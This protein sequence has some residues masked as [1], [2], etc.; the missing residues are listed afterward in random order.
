MKLMQWWLLHRVP[1]DMTV[2][3]QIEA[4]ACMR[5]KI[6]YGNGRSQEA[7]SKPAREGESETALSI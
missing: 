4:A 3:P 5:F 1:I 2:T 7:V 6:Q